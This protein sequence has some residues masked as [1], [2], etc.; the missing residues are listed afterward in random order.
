M[1]SSGNRSNRNRSSGSN[2]NGNRT[3]CCLGREKNRR[4]PSQ[5][6]LFAP[7][8]MT[9]VGAGRS[10][11]REASCFQTR[12]AK[13]KRFPRC[14]I[15]PC[16]LRLVLQRF[17]KI[18]ATKYWCH[19]CSRLLHIHDMCARL[20]PNFSSRPEGDRVRKKMEPISANPKSF[21]FQ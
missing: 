5:T 14:N 18:E 10:R 6:V 17:C 20:A 4:K 2:T 8:C 21:C 7:R 16:W 11:P 12:M 9:V 3:Y 1:H 15:K 13:T 19:F